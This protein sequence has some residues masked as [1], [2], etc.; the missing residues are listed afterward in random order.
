MVG[1]CGESC[2]GTPGLSSS[3]G[4]MEAL[5]SGPSSA[6]TSSRGS[7]D[8]LT[9]SAKTRQGAACACAG[10][11]SVWEDRGGETVSD[12]PERPGCGTPF[13]D[14]GICR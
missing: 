1:V 4:E 9:H 13:P 14:V 5:E 12:L 6:P 10:H 11:C 3:S 7:V 8:S 2:S